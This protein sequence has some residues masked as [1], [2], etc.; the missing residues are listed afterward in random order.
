MK[1]RSNTESVDDIQRKLAFQRGLLSLMKTTVPLYSP[2]IE[3]AME[4]IDDIL[5]KVG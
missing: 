2:M 1:K 5:E 4:D 3:K